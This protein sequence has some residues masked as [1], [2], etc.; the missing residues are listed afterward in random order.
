[1]APEGSFAKVRKPVDTENEVNRE[2]RRT[3]LRLNRTPASLEGNSI[4]IVPQ[5]VFRRTAKT[6]GQREFMNVGRVSFSETAGGWQKELNIPSE[7]TSFR[8]S[9]ARGRRRKAWGGSLASL[10]LPEVLPDLSGDF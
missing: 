10:S 5:L 3:K 7:W 4:I 9:V 2:T 8:T 1:V 6:F